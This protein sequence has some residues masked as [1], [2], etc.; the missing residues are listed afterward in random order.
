MRADGAGSSMP[1]DLSAYRI[2]DRKKFVVIM[3]VLLSAVAVGVWVGLDR[4]ADYAKQ[5]EALTATDPAKAAV[6]ITRQLR[7]LAVLNGILLA[8]LAALII[9][10]GLRGLRTASMPPKGSWIMEGQRIWT[11]Q[12]ALRIAKFKIAVGALLVVLAVVGS[13]ILWRIGDMFQG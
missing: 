3:A 6:I 12:S 10:Q 8:M 13:L 5:L 2:F 11:G 9:W 4:L 1:D 7:I